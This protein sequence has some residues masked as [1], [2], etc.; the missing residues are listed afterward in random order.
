MGNDSALAES[1][2]AESVGKGSALGFDAFDADNHYYEAPDAY[3]RHMPRAMQKRAMQWADID[4]KRRLLVGGKVNKFI[5]NPLF[6]P[7]AKPG[8]LYD[9]FKGDN[10]DGINLIAAFGALEPIRPEYR[11]REARVQ[12]MDTQGLGAAWLFPTLGVGMEESLKHDPEAMVAAFSAFNRWLEE[13][14]GFNFDDRL[15]AAPVITLV[16]L[17][18]AIVELEWA[19]AHD[20]RVICMRQAPVVTPAGSRSPAD[21]I[22]DPFWARVNEAGITVA[23]HA[24]DDGYGM[25]A[26]YWEPTGSM[27]A[28]R[29]T[30]LRGVILRNRAI[31][32]YL[33]ALICHGLFDRFP[34]LRVAS[35]ENGSTW[36]PGLLKSLKKSHLQNPGFFSQSPVETFHRNISVAPFWEDD[37]D[38]LLSV[39]P[40]D[41]VIF[42]SDWPHAE[43]LVAPIDYVS[44]LVKLPPEDVRMIMRDNALALTQRRPA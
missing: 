8:C 26:D 23:V 31:H 35:I 7:V 43:G 18:A 6:D 20:V 34:N 36:V 4:G 12:V 14:W 19:L 30:P 42:G 32:D 22:F 2:L 5:P 33:A 39:L 28:F 24:G 37:V 17:D 11:D 25:F 10:P 1:A 27:E 13:D 40:T 38:Y 9:F 3:I 15:F 44:E 29:T 16:D 41:R 21:P